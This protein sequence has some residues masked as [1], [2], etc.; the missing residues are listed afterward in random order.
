MDN[1]GP[2]PSSHAKIQTSSFKALGGVAFLKIHFL[3]QIGCI[4]GVR[5]HAPAR[6]HAKLYVANH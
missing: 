5:T 1:L 3:A 4:Y 2:K 6:T